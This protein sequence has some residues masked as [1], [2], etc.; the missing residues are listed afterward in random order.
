M[1]NAQLVRYSE[2]FR[3]LEIPRS[4]IEYILIVII[5]F[6]TSD[7]A[8]RVLWLVHSISII[9]SYPLIWPYILNDCAKRFFFFFFS[10][11]KQ[12]LFLNEAK[13]E[14][15]NFFLWKVWINSDVKKYAKKQEMFCDEPTSVWLQ[16]ITH[17]LI[18]IKFFRFRWNFLAFFASISYF[19][20][21]GV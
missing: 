19:Q 17:Y 5:K 18:F 12:N 14:K 9:S 6:S 1:N 20:I 7:N 21:F 15:K 4:L 3:L 13:K 11:G 8:F 16:G 2:P 10:A